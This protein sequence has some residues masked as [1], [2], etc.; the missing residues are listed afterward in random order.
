MKSKKAASLAIFIIIA[1]LLVGAIVLFF[2]FKEQLGI[3]T[4]PREVSQ[5]YDYFSSCVEEETRMAALTMGSQAGYLE[6][7]EFEPGSDYMP[8]SSQ[9]DF[10]GA[11]PYW[12]YVSGNGIAKEQIPSKKKMEEQLRLY[13]KERIDECSFREFEQ[14]GFTVEKGDIDVGV[15]IE[16][17][18]I[19][20]DVTMPL[21]VSFGESKGTRTEH[22]VEVNSKLG[23]FYSLASEIYNKEQQT[24]FLEN[25]G[26]DILRLYAPVDGSEIGCSP[27]MWSKLD[28]RENLTSALEANT[29]A[30]KIKGDY[31]SLGKEENKYFVQDLG[32]RIEEEV[33]FLYL[34]DW[35]MKFEVW[36]SESNILMAEPVGLQEGLGILGFCYVPYHFVY[37]FSYPVLIQIYDGEEIFQFPVAVVIDKNTPRQAPDVEGLPEV[38]PELCEHKLTEMKVYTYDTQLDPVPARIKYKCFDTSCYIGDSIL[39]GQDAVLAASFPQCI[40]GY[41]IA[42]AEGYKTAKFVKS[43]VESGEAIMVLDKEYN[44]DLEVTKQGSS[45]SEEYAIVTF[46][47]EDTITT[48]Y[49]EQKNI[50]LAEGDY[51][52]RVYVYANS[53]ITLAGSKT[54]KCVEVAKSGI[55]GV[56]GATDEKCFTL[57]IPEQVVSFAVSGGGTQKYYVTESELQSGKL[58]IDV[59]NFGKPTK[60]EE[61]QENYNKIQ[62][63]NLDIQ[64]G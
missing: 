60:V 59:S 17:T 50:E 36:P 41:I 30:I 28:V 43:T 48:V 64:F 4:I 35:P 61:L 26:V 46:S 21:T 12:Y 52:V 16:E 20:V 10:M 55:P 40:N 57:E 47:G 24:E 39:E 44:L 19:N 25:Y 32:E 42:E 18:K 37:D 34:R 8:F 1:I 49:P 38:V 31:Y 13:L 9:L 2:L 14:S 62:T 22:K 54:E 15:T 63:E 53:T 29:R 33:N 51:E 7:P 56:F 3:S 23:K 27:K 58:K 11:V 6:L 5:V 45:L